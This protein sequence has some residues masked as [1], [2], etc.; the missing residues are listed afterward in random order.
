MRSNFQQKILLNYLCQVSQNAK[1]THART[2]YINLDI[3]ILTCFRVS[4]DLSSSPRMA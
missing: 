3:N 1:D 2:R 4:P